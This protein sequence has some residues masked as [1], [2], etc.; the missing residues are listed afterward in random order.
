MYRMKDGEHKIYAHDKLRKT[1]MEN[2]G[3]TL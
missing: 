3:E 2:Q 1:W